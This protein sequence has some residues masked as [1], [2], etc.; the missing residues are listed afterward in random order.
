MS[1]MEAHPIALVSHATFDGGTN[2]AVPCPVLESLEPSIAP[3]KRARG[4]GHHATGPLSRIMAA[5]S[6]PT[7]SSAGPVEFPGWT[8]GELDLQRNAAGRPEKVR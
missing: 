4:S 7:E 5:D 2:R 1:L 6:G 3:N 8:V